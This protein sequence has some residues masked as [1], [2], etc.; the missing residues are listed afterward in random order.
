MGHREV[1]GMENTQKLDEGESIAKT[2]RNPREKKSDM[3]LK[4]QAVMFHT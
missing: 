4:S 3:S 1:E 2:L